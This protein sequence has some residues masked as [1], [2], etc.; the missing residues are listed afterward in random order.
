M[1]D[2]PASSSRDRELGNC[3]YTYLVLNPMSHTFNVIEAIR[4]LKLPGPG[5]FLLVFFSEIFHDFPGH[6]SQGDSGVNLSFV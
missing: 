1:V 2:F 3:S 4:S 6:G 5:N